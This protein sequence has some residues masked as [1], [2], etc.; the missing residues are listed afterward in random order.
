M[1]YLLFQL[2]IW[3]IVAL[4]IGLFVGWW[5][6][7]RRLQLTLE[8]HGALEAQHTTQTNRLLAFE[9][10]MDKAKDEA[11]AHQA[12]ATDLQKQLERANQALAKSKDE[13][14]ALDGSLV[15]REKT[16]AKLQA[17]LDTKDQLLEESKQSLA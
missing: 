6:W 9:G 3:L 10:D 1:I 8:R 17:Q 4:L 11:R 12:E 16:I 15:E 2:A 14:K 5:I 7:A 13:L